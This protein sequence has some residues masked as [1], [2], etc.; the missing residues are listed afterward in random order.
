MPITP[1]L[2]AAYVPA[3]SSALRPGTMPLVGSPSGST[4]GV[5]SISLS[6]STSALMPTS[7]CSSFVA[8]PRELV[9]LVGV[10]AAAVEV[11][12]A[13][14]GPGPRVAGRVVER[15]EE[16]E[17]V[18][19]RRP[20][21]SPPTGGRRRRPRVD[22]RVRRGRGRLDPVQAEVEARARRPCSATVSP[23][24][25]RLVSENGWPFGWR[26]TG[27]FET[28]RPS[29]S[30]IRLRRFRSFRAVYAAEPGSS[31][32]VGVNGRDSPAFGSAS[33]I[34]PNWS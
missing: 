24:R 3:P 27:G 16:V 26:S 28:P 30:V 22:G 31:I 21:A 2:I 18:L 5:F 4:P 19:R 8:L 29:S 20:A 9:G 15:E 14:A 33:T 7:V 17:R 10:R 12:V 1:V 23:P 34:S 13:A 6:P 11:R 25:K 32:E